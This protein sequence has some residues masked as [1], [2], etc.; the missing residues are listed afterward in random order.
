MFHLY[1][2][3]SCSHKMVDV[4]I[5]FVYFSFT[6][7]QIRQNKIQCLHS[8]G[9]WDMGQKGG[10]VLST[11][12]PKSMFSM[13]SSNFLRAG[14]GVFSTSILMLDMRSTKQMF[15][16]CCNTSSSGPVQYAWNKMLGNNEI[17]LST[18]II[19]H[20][21][22][23]V[24]AAAAWRHIH[25]GRLWC[26]RGRAERSKCRGG[27]LWYRCL[28]NERNQQC[29]RVWPQGLKNERN[30]LCRRLWP[31]G[32]LSSVSQI[33]PADLISAFVSETLRFLPNQLVRYE[34]L[35]SLDAH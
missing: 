21:T 22:K 34:T 33:I 19:K 10:S 12:N 6:F 28:K 16:K 9:S 29:G 26:R 24:S 7:S 35:R 32:L 15:R 5:F 14:R 27:N 25:T 17:I 13:K 2:Q 3:C 4:L 23:R 31:Q 8:W 30:Q 1:L 18:G 20:K 11:S